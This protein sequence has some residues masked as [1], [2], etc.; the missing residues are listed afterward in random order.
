MRSMA[1]FVLGALVLVFAPP[2]K[3]EEWDP[4]TEGPADWDPTMTSIGRRGGRSSGATP[5]ATHP[6]RRSRSVTLTAGRGR[7]EATIYGAVLAWP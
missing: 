3:W 2:R 7:A 1:L 6:S 4:C 5:G